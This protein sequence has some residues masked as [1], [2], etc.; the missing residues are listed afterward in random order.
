MLDQREPVGLQCR[1]V[2]FGTRR[3]QHAALFEGLPDGGERV[4]L[5]VVAADVVGGVDYAAGKDATCRPRRASPCGA[6]S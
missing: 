6:G 3:Q 5:L 4:G 1:G 2:D